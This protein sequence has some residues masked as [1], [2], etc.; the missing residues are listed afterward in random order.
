MSSNS[1]GG[2]LEGFMTGKGFYIVLFLCA[3]VIG[4]SAWMM[5]AG[6][7]AME[8]L[9][10]AGAGFE[11]K[12]VETVIITPAPREE[13]VETAALPSVTLEEPAEAVQPVW[14]EAEETEGVFFVWPVEGEPERLHDVQ[15][16]HYDVTLRDWRTHNGVDIL[17]PLGQTVVAARG[18]VVQSV[19]NDGL[20]GTVVTVDHGDG[21]TACYANLADLPAVGAGDRVETG[22]VIGAVGTTALCEIGQATHLHFAMAVDGMSVDPLDY[23]PGE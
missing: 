20:Y 11:E 1:S 9:A 23:L 12:R 16:L 14:N 8:E 15:S 19:E 5:A 6:N 2:R 7:G 3:A 13:R 17:A 22:D 18:G 10:P 21:S 4:L